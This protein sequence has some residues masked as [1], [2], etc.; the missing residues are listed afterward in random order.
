[1]AGPA[2]LPHVLD[3]RFHHWRDSGSIPPFLLWNTRS[4]SLRARA[5]ERPLCDWLH[6]ADPVP[7]LSGPLP[8]YKRRSFGDISE[9]CSSSEILDKSHYPVEE[10]K[11]VSL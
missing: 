6:E 2:C 11:G 8:V 9:V 10:G 7:P 1:M 5:P 3:P 4:T